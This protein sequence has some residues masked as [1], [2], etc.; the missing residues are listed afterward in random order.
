MGAKITI[1]VEFDRDDAMTG[2][3]DAKVVNVRNVTEDYDMDV[4]KNEPKREIWV[5]AEWLHSSLALVLQQDV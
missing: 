2:V 5:L 3:I 1:E 4:F